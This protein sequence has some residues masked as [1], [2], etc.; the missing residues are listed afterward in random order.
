MNNK[1]LVRAVF[2]QCN[3]EFVCMCVCLL[4]SALPSL[5]AGD[6]CI[7]MCAVLSSAVTPTRY[8]RQKHLLASMVRMRAM[9]PNVSGASLANRPQLVVK[10]HT[11][12]KI[13]HNFAHIDSQGKPTDITKSVCKRCFKAKQTEEASTCN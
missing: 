3:S 4:L 5:P 2:C 6:K 7:Y 12:S 1:V 13:G 9:A 11:W 8:C 10:V